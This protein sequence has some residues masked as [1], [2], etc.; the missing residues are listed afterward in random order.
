VRQ[1]ILQVAV[2]LYL[3]TSC[4]GT[5]HAADCSYELIEQSFR[6]QLTYTDARALVVRLCPNARQVPSI[7]IALG[8]IEKFMFEC[9][10]DSCY[11]AL[12]FDPPLTRARIRSDNQP[13]LMKCELFCRHGQSIE[14]IRFST[15]SVDS[16]TRE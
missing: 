15:W 9:G 7:A 10:G 4:S 1:Y 6:E 3:T 5:K 2:L 14:N 13:R 16:N 8:P 11:I 12:F